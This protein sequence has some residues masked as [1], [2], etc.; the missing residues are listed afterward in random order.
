MLGWIDM[1]KTSKYVC[2]KFLLC[3]LYST[4]IYGIKYNFTIIYGLSTSLQKIWRI[5]SRAIN[6]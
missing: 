6:D 5:F 4:I 3:L 1:N 2:K